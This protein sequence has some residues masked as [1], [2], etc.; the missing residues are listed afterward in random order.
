MKLGSIL[1][2]LAIVIAG[3]IYVLYNWQEYGSLIGRRGYENVKLVDLLG[4]ANVYDGKEVCTVGYVVEGKN[5]IFIKGEISEN[6]F[7][8]AAWLVNA[9]GKTFLFNTSGNIS[10]AQNARICGKFESKKGEYY[11]NPSFWKHQIT[12]G[13]FQL[14]DEP[15]IVDY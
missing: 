1:T 6:K 8:G 15:F 9:S 3:L 14:Q 2:F 10:R 7:E 12:V 11:G 4:F 5:S 13:E